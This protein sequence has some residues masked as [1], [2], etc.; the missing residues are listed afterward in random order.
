MTLPSTTTVFAC[1]VRGQGILPYSV[2]LNP[3]FPEGNLAQPPQLPVP[4][5]NKQFEQV[6]YFIPDFEFTDR[7]QVVK[8]S[9]KNHSDFVKTY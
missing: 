3:S 9:L 6:E 2:C 1:T 8:N 5:Q 4:V 7:E